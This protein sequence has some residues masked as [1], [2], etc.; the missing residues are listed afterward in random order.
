MHI[1]DRPGGGEG[2]SGLLLQR[3]PMRRTKNTDTDL[4]DTIPASPPLGL[5]LTGRCGDAA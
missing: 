1:F 5:L 3:T 4:S 2:L